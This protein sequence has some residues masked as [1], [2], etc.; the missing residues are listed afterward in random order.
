AAVEADGSILMVLDGVALAEAALDSAKRNRPAPPAMAAPLEAPAVEASATPSI[1]VADD[2]L[3][4]REL[5]RSILEQ[6]GYRV[7]VAE[8]GHAALGV[9]TRDRIDLVLT[10]VEMPGM[11]GFDL[12]RAIRAH[13]ELANVPVVIL[14]S[15]TSAE[16]HQ[17]GLDAGAD[18]YIVKEAF[19]E[20]ILLAAVER[21]LGRVP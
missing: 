21:L 9:L 2:A 15:K 17:E 5:Q 16:D 18:A 10:D 3:L 20:A 12:T 4:V 14:T 11:N 13:P 6:A 7:L 1:L 8:D 19:G